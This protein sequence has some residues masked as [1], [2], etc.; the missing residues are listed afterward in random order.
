MFFV[1]CMFS[2]KHNKKTD[3]KNILY[4]YFHPFSLKLTNGMSSSLSKLDFGDWIHFIM[5]TTIVR[6]RTMLKM[7]MMATSPGFPAKSLF[8]HLSFSPNLAERAESRDTKQK[9]VIFLSTVYRMF[10]IMWTSHY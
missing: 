5:M 6:V 2:E 1:L 3:F 10:L 7:Q 4:I 8:T 9:E